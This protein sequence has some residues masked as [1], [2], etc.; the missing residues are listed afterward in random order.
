MD[1]SG[2]HHGEA[3]GGGGALYCWEEY[4]A[5]PTSR[6]QE[7]QTFHPATWYILHRQ[8]KG[9]MK[10]GTFAKT[11]LLLDLGDVHVDIGNQEG[12]KMDVA[13]CGGFRRHLVRA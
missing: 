1:R 7:D 13:G 5:P 9:T 3:H 2:Y 12:R 10:S 8:N 11:H 6:V 4:V